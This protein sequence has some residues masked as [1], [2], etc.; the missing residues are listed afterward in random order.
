MKLEQEKIIVKVKRL[1]KDKEEKNLIFNI[2][3]AFIIKGVSLF[4]AF[5]SMPLYMK[6]FGNNK[7]L[8]V[9]YTILSILSWITICDLGF[10]NG[11]RN[12][13]TEA[14]SKC[15]FEKARKYISSTYILLIVVICPIIFLGSVLI[16]YFDLNKFFKISIDIISFKN[17][18]LGFFILFLGVCVN[19]VLKLITSII[20]AI[21]K[22]AINNCISLVTSIIPVC[23]ILIVPDKGVNINFIALSFIYFIALNI[24]LI[25][26]SIFIFKKKGLEKCKPNIRDFDFYAAKQMLNIGL[27]FFLAQIS[28]M[29]LMSTNEVF[30]V[31]LFAT[32][33]IVEYSIYYKLFMVV[34]SLFMLALTPLWSKITKDLSERKY[35]KIKKTNKYLYIISGIAIVIEFLVIPMLQPIINFWLRE[36]AIQ[37]NYITGIVFAIYGSLYIL[38]IV[39]TTVANGIGKLTTQIY[40]YGFGAI[41]KFLGIYLLRYLISKWY[42]VILYNCIILF[43]FCVVQLFWIEKAIKKIEKLDII[44]GNKNEFI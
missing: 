38:N 40:F 26:V 28:F 37:V 35:Y 11:L 4:V 29:V 9:W 14:Y 6:Y 34:G 10:G 20:Y 31:K 3:G 2:F 44:G 42:V 24:P 15:E 41:F 8:G 12:K 32:D 25:I 27:K 43:L 19:F 17:F 30:I 13:F 16:L 7:I 5:F 18:K 1:L 21:Q 22:A 33:D 36:Q 23:F 39:L